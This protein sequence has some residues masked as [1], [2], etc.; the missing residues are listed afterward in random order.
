MAIGKE[1]GDFTLKSITTGYALEGGIVQINLDG[2]ATGYG[3]VLGTLT[4]RGEPGAKSGPLSW[5][6]QGFLDTGD[7]V[8][9]TGEGTWEEMGKH[10]WGTRLIV[11]TSD[12]KCHASDGHLDLKTR[13]LSGKDVGVELS[14]DQTTL[15]LVRDAPA[16]VGCCFRGRRAPLADNVRGRRRIRTAAQNSHRIVS[17]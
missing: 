4:F 12:G 13:T 16:S 7:T 15:D 8:T 10:K 9:G 11:S 2:P 3:T 6:G 1:I 5:R 17:D 14:K